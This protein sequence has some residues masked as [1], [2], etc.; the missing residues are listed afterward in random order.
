[1]NLN[2]YSRL[3]FLSFFLIFSCETPTEEEVY[4]EDI[5][6]LVLIDADGI[7]KKIFADQYYGYVEKY[8]VNNDS[9]ILIK[10]YD[11][12]VLMNIDDSLVKNISLGLEMR[13]SCISHDR[14]KVAF[15]GTVNSEQEIYLMH[16]DGRNLHSITSTPNLQKRFPEFS[17]DGNLLVYATIQNNTPSIEVV[18]ISSGLVTSIIKDTVDSKKSIIPFWYP[19]FSR[20]DELI[21]FIYEYWNSEKSVYQTALC[22][23]DLTGNNF[24]IVENDVSR[25]GNI[26]TSSKSEKLFYVAGSNPLHLFVSDYNGL[27]KIDLGETPINTLINIARND[28]KIVFGNESSYYEDDVVVMNLDGSVRKILSKG[29]SPVLSTDGTKV[30]FV[31]MEYLRY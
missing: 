3:L 15:I 20:N 11:D 31:K 17:H 4:Y 23:I 26:K 18:D 22:S 1:M 30:L 6:N 28:T 10:R 14:S 2:K 5:Y 12:F 29:G 27:N 24:K 8:F 16:Y 25:L 9:Q 19:C 21:F 13:R 7:N